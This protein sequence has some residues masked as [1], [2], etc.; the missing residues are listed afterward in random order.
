MLNGGVTLTMIPFEDNGKIFPCLAMYR[1]FV[2]RCDS[3]VD[4]EQLLPVVRCVIF[5]EWCLESPG[6][7]LLMT[8]CVCVS[9]IG[10]NNM[11]VKIRLVH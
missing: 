4:T 5:N 11:A 2:H 1:K 7:L 10:V 3:H 6:S 8:E 9:K